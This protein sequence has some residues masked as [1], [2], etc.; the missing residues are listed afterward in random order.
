MLRLGI[1]GADALA[2]DM[3]KLVAE[4]PKVTSDALHKVADNFNNDVNEKFPSS[5]EERFR[6]WKVKGAKEGTSS[7]VTSTNKAPHFHLVENGHAKYD[8]HGHYTGG[9]VPGKHYAEQIRQIYQEKYPKMM[10]DEISY[11]LTKHYL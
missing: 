1:D 3:K 4:C 11:L 6:E 7:F 9:F 10:M 2:E 8:F 5:Y